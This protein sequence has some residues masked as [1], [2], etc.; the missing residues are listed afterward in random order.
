MGFLSGRRGHEIRE[1]VTTAEAGVEGDRQRTEPSA[2]VQDTSI[3]G[4]RVRFQELEDGAVPTT[5]ELP[6]RPLL[7]RGVR[8]GP[9]PLEGGTDCGAKA[10]G[11]GHDASPPFRG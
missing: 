11:L 3:A 1:V 10:L 9:K 6:A 2:Q 7:G 5:A 8:A 4:R